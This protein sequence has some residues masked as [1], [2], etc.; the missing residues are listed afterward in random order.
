[1]GASGTMA[2]NDRSITWTTSGSPS[3][4]SKALARRLSNFCPLACTSNCPA[5]V[6]MTPSLLSCSFTLRSDRMMA[7]GA[8]STAI[9]RPM[10]R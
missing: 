5:S 1:M 9:H 6:A 3:A 4:M 7:I 8:T 10:T 2:E